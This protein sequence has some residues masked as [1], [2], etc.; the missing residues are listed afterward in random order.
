MQYQSE[1]LFWLLSPSEAVQMLTVVAERVKHS[2]KAIQH[3]SSFDYTR[4]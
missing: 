3:D 2:Q 4:P 1:L